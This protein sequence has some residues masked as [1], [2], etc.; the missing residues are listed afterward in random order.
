MDN[1]PLVSVVIPTYNRASL[2]RETI[3]SVLAQTYKPIEIIV[4]NDG[5]TDDTSR[6]LDED[7]AG[8]VIHLLKANGGGTAARNSGIQAAR[9]QF[10]NVL[11]HDD[12]F[13]PQ[14]I[15]LQVSML[16]QHPGMGLAH[17][18]YYRM[19]KDGRYIDKVTQLPDGDVRGEIVKGC[20]CWSGGP[21]IRREIFDQVGLFDERI[22]SSDADMWLKIAL[23]GW[24]F[25]CIQE[26]MGAYRILTDSSMA[27]VERTERMDSAILEWVSVYPN[28]PEAAQKNLKHGYFNQRFWLGCRFYTIGRYDDAKRN[29]SESLTIIPE[30]LTTPISISHLFLTNALDPRVADPVAWINN[31]FDNLPAEIDALLQPKRRDIIAHTYSGMA[32]RSYAYG[33]LELASTQ[34]TSAI[35]YD[36]AIPERGEDFERMLVDFALRLPVEPHEYVQTVYQHLP[37][38]AAPLR[39]TMDRV[40]SGVNISSAFRDYRAGKHDTVPRKVLAA[41]RHQP[42]LLA[43]RGVWSI[44]VRSTLSRS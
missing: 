18:G 10:I 41:V 26:P 12:L 35:E 8:R 32:M 36:P 30:M 22:W 3:D 43:N 31:V 27:D 42:E 40:I 23:A 13:L 39:K 14:K 2:L 9:G 24:E 11:D 20:F 37:P 1:R 7:Y 34:F 28:L 44:L 15:E 19:N 5:S 29:I 16:L 4:V 6:M 25:G 33:E 38:Q 17:C 21:L